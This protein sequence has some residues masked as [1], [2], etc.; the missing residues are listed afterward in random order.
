MLVTVQRADGPIVARVFTDNLGNYDV[1]G[2]GAG[3]YNILVNVEGYEEVRQEVGIGN[4]AFSNV[5]V[6][7]PLREKEKFIVIRPPG[8]AEDDIVDI[9]ELGRKHPKKAVQDYDKAQDEA[10]KGNTSKAIDLLLSAVKIAPD[11]YS[12]HNSLGTLYQRAG[13]FNDA[14]AE[15]RRARVLNPRAAEPLVNLGSLFIDQAVA[16]EHEGREVVGKILD[17]A[18]DILEESLKLKRSQK[19]YYFLGT[20]YY[21]SNFFEEAETNLK[22]ANEMEP[23]LPAANLMLANLYIKQRKWQDALDQLDTYL[24]ENPNA[25]DR[26]QI[27]GTRAKVAERVR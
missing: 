11:F 18:L 22:R 15:Y 2:L 24:N 3:V 10:R 7:I 21:R 6:N 27:L 23:N 14:E 9:A 26:E 19:G 12:A 13:K 8:A 1:R 4:G 25:S 5:T 16:R 17:Q 20:A